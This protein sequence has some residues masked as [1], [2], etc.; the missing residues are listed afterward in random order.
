MANRASFLLDNTRISIIFL[1]LIAIAI[2]GVLLSHTYRFTMWEL[3]KEYNLAIFCIMILICITGQ[4][5][6][7]LFVRQRTTLTTSSKNGFRILFKAISA[8]QYILSAILLIIT[9]QVIAI[10]NY[11]P[12]FVKAVIWISYIEAAFL[13]GVLCYKFYR[14]LRSSQTYLIFFYTISIA[15][16]TANLLFSL[17]YIDSQIA[18]FS[19]NIQRHAGGYVPS[20]IDTVL[21]SGFQLSSV[22]SYVLVWIATIAF[23]KNYAK[24]FGNVRYWIVV[25]LPLL[26]FALQFQPFILQLL[27]EY[28]L[29][30]PILFSI[31]YTLFFSISKLAGAILFGIG[32]LV[33]SRK[34]TNFNLRNFVK[35]SG[36][37]LI[38]F[39][40]SNQVILLI[41]MPNPPF[42]VI[43]ISLVGLASYLMLIGIY[44]SASSV[45]QDISLRA[46]IRK[47]VRDQTLFLD[48]IATSEM[49]NS[50]ETKVLEL[51]KRLSS[52]AEDMSG[53]EPPAEEDMKTYLQE[54]LE[55]VKRT[56]EQE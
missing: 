27:V 25:S 44:Y 49:E 18:I 48:K 55:E 32:F 13:T 21:T 53:I 41:N 54:A 8:V 31:T 3:E 11:D 39:F 36:Y 30:E 40:T 37:G 46:I 52:Q 56:K 22:V 20:N 35:L 15:S 7:A 51:T 14:W 34:I 42:G 9:Y 4:N 38:L 10:S 6:V 47:S 17:F 29:L 1:F 26:Y 19:S 33:I 16:L 43:T 2:A 12:G 24:S 45:A 23:L 50:I 28:R 5:F